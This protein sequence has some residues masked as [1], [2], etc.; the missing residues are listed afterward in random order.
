MKKSRW[1]WVLPTWLA[2]GLIYLFVPVV[3]V[4]L[5]SFNDV[6][7][8]FNVRWQGFTLEHWMEPF[9]VP[10]IP[11]ALGTSLVIAFLSALFATVL[12]TLIALATVRYR[13]RGR[14]GTNVSL[15]MP[16]ATPEVVLGSSLLALF[17]A[18]SIGT[19]FVTILI[20]HILFEV[21]YAV[22]TV[23]ARIAG[24]DRHLEEAAMDLYADEW[25]TF[26][27]ITLPMI[28]PGVFAAFLLSFALSIDDF[29]VTN[30]TS[31][32]VQTFP[33]YVWGAARRGIPPQVNVW[34]TI[35]FVSTVTVMMI[36]LRIQRRREGKLR[37]PEFKGVDPDPIRDVLEPVG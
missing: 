2:V 8:R 27:R 15:F 4:I 11:E 20:A 33:L 35:I 13:F 12:G 30:F 17:I 5:F 29:V 37:T 26:R 1:R 14:S 7:G 31:G 32:S 3:L 9:K 22:A 24:F 28:M 6:Q 18:V 16:M 36:F 34:G 10:A 25:Q 23:R 19:G 21:S